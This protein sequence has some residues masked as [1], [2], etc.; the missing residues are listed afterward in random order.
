MKVI[1]MKIHLEGPSKG[2]CLESTT[3][4]T[5]RALTCAPMKF[6]LAMGKRPLDLGP[7]LPRLNSAFF[8]ARNLIDPMLNPR[9]ARLA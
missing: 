4:W 5:R 1:D 6:G 2:M 8:L 3:G 7:G 9:G